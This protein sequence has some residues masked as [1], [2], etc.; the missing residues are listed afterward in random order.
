MTIPDISIHFLNNGISQE[1]SLRPT[2]SASST[3]DF[4]RVGGKQY[5]IVGGTEQI[6][7]AKTILKNIPESS[8]DTID[9]FKAAFA[10]ASVG[11][12]DR[13]HS[14]ATI[15]LSLSSTASSFSS[16]SFSSSLPADE[17]DWLK[18]EKDIKS[19]ANSILSDSKVK[20][21]TACF[22]KYTS[23]TNTSDPKGLREYLV[24]VA[25]DEGDPTDRKVLAEKFDEAL[26][27]KDLKSF[28][29]MFDRANIGDL[30]Q[31]D[32]EEDLNALPRKVSGKIIAITDTNING[33]KKYMQA[34]GFSG[35]VSFMDSRLPRPIT[36]KS[37]N[38]ESTGKEEV[39]FSV[40]SVSKVHTGILAIQLMK[41]GILPK[42]AMARPL[43]LDEAVRKVLPETVLKQLAKTN[44]H[45]AMLHRA[46]L[47]DYAKQYEKLIQVHVEIGLDPPVITKPE[48]FLQFADSQITE[49]TYS[50][51]GILLVGLSLQ[52][53]YNKWAKARGLPTKTIEE[54][55][56][57]YVLDP[58]ETSLSTHRPPNGRYNESDPAAQYIVGSPAG[59][60]WTSTEDLAQ[61]GNWFRQEYNRD[62]EK[63]APLVDAFGGE[64][65]NIKD[66][67]L[68]HVGAI[69]SS[70]AALVTFIDN[71]VSVAIASDL[72]DLAAA[73]MYDA[74]ELHILQR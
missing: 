32:H 15:P 40:H 26:R 12:T 36:V 56:K 25:V 66:K 49:N 9:T 68:F 59:G 45:A 33:L 71:G 19:K 74:I 61:L 41:A 37:K 50:N 44:M 60:G 13:T 7:V 62:K 21:A 6:A 67:M 57:E 55:T 30:R 4:V 48:D 63:F 72:P 39:P 47:G 38:L 43:E 28:I 54:L 35:V 34:I 1:I 16:S 27:S 29:E 69:D 46:N 24:N 64:F 65:F 70:S 53:H 42:E 52:H 2:E 18:R 73:K 17:E 58:S 5:K 20:V 3:T 22:A 11:P 31:I 23:E 14:A 10:S 8:F 51:L